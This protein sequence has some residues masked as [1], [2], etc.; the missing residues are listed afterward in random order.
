MVAERKELAVNSGEIVTGHSACGAF[1]DEAAVQLIDF[2]LV[3]Y[4]REYV[5]ES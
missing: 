1:L 2:L 3:D 5:R 4:E